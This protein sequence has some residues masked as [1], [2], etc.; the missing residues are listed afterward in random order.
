MTAH[1]KPKKRKKTR[2]RKQKH[3]YAL[4]TCWTERVKSTIPGRENATAAPEL[5]GGGEEHNRDM[6]SMRHNPSVR[7]LDV[8]APQGSNDAARDA[9]RGK[10]S[11]G[12]PW[13]SL[14][15]KLREER[16]AA[17]SVSHG[18]EREGIT[19]EDLRDERVSWRDLGVCV[20]VCVCVCAKV[21]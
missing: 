16:E 7:V 19:E 9:D 20:C 4:R 14:E 15:M 2:S 10:R 8:R 6:A 5:A 18:G 1:T 11:E 13:E 3:N 12:E 17:G 21:C